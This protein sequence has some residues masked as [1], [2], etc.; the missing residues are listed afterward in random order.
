MGARGR[1]VAAVLASLAL[2]AA[3]CTGGDV[4]PTDEATTTG[5]TVSAEPGSFAYVNA[6]I[7]ATLAFDGATGE[8]EVA[9]GSGAD[10]GAPGVYALDALTGERTD[11]MVTPARGVSD[12]G[13]GTFEVAFPAGTDPS[14]AGFLGLELGGEDYGGFVGA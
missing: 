14:A 4:R 7:Q 6:G 8:L 3:A 9:N 5:P 12:G 1:V 13:V 10:V 11:A 2:G